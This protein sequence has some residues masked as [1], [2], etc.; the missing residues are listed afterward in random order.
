[1]N[2]GDTHVDAPEPAET[3][4]EVL[5]AKVDLA[6][7]IY[8]A[9]SSTAYGRPAYQDLELRL[10]NQGLYGQG[11]ESLPI[12]DL[13]KKLA[14]DM[15]EQNR[16][17]QTAQR[18]NELAD[19]QNLGGAYMEAIDEA[20]P[21]LAQLRAA[22]GK[23]G[24]E[25]LGRSY[26]TT[27]SEE[28][29]RDA[30]QRARQGY[31]DRGM[32]RSNPSVGA[33]VLQT[34]KYRHYLEDRARTQEDM[35]RRYALASGQLVGGM[36]QD[37]LQAV[38]GRPG[39]NIGNNAMAMGQ[40]AATTMGR[41]QYYDPFDSVYQ[42]HYGGQLQADISNQE[43]QGGLWGGLLGMGGRLGGALIRR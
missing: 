11:T 17:A 24:M 20:N 25:A 16:I 13:G 41:P 28:G 15:A 37:P 12:V 23:S 2:C 3:S 34:E 9:E 36:S 35:D 26:E 40:S 6:P 33:E 39:H 19:V 10:L 4:R 7:R 43:F 5:Q 14:A 30:R 32:F 8:A 21:E 29:L 31:A 42:Q 38:L 27:P 18:Q 22:L 1:M